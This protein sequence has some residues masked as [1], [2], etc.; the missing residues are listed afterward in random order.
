MNWINLIAWV[1]ILWARYRGE[2]WMATQRNSN[3]LIAQQMC[4]FEGGSGVTTSVGNANPTFP[5]FSPHFSSPSGLIKYSLCPT[6][7]WQTRRTDCSTKFWLFRVLFQRSYK[8]IVSRNLSPRCWRQNHN[9]AYWSPRCSRQNHSTAIESLRAL[10]T[11]GAPFFKSVSQ[12]WHGLN[13][14]IL[15]NL[16]SMKSSWSGLSNELSKVV[17]RLAEPLFRASN[18]SLPKFCGTEGV[19]P[20]VLPCLPL[21]SL[22]D[23]WDHWCTFAW[24]S[25]L[26]ESLAY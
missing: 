1:G 3:R 11:I 16:L 2:W 10:A 4:E 14:L 13:I 19:V 22:H 7:F 25:H 23:K 17:I 26:L 12:I 21:Q 9:T 15:M 18:D 8:T 24:W 5:P 6:K 20:M